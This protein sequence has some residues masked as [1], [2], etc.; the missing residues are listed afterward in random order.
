VSDWLPDSRPDWWGTAKEFFSDPES[1]V[2]EWV[3]GWLI[4]GYLTFYTSVLEVFQ[5]PFEVLQGATWTIFRAFGGA[6]R[7]M[8][9]AYAG[10]LQIIGGAL[11]LVATAG[12]PFGFVIGFA[13][14]A[15]FIIALSWALKAL[16]RVIPVL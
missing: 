1:K 6:L 4:A 14:F 2:R 16:I 15:A 5:T 10:A 13:M 7:Q 8:G 9:L 12:G 3:A 11:E